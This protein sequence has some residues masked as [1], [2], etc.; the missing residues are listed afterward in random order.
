MS[1]WEIR[2][3]AEDKSR[4][5]AELDSTIESVCEKIKN[6]DIVVGEYHDTV[7]ALAMLVGARASLSGSD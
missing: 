3:Q 5:I 1:T 6:E 4:L 2:K 7:K